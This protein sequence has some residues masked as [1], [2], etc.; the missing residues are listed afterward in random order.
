MVLSTVLALLLVRN[1]RT[2][3]TVSVFAAASLKDAFTSIARSYEAEHPGIHV[4]LTFA[5]SQTLATQINQGAPAD[6]F[7]SASMKNLKEANPDPSSIRVFA[8]NRL[9][10]VERA[11]WN[12]VHSLKDLSSVPKLVLAA[13]PVPAGH[14]AY[15]LLSNAAKQYGPAWFR[16]VESHVV[17]REIDVR[18]VLAKVRLGEADAGIVYESDAVWPGAGDGVKIPIR[19]TSSPS[20]RWGC[21]RSH[22]TRTWARLEVSLS[23]LAQSELTKQ[24]FIS[25]IAASNRIVV[26]LYW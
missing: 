1:A 25:P 6:V 24:G 2:D 3:A 9:T 11:G 19:S 21:F 4:M 13:D 10:I 18:A 5:G 14:Y 20:I 17:S 12:G 22:R 8:L 23:P 15:E 26:A 16:S 7:A